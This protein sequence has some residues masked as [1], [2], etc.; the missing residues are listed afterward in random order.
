MSTENEDEV[1]DELST[2]SVLIGRLMDRT[3]VKPRD[4]A[5]VVGEALKVPY[6]TARRRLAGTTPWTIAELRKVAEHQNLSF[7]S[8]FT[9][10][11][12][13]P[14][15]AAMLQIDEQLLP[16][17]VWI[18]KA[19]RRSRSGPL[20]AYRDAQQA[21]IVGRPQDAPNGVTY[22]LTR[23]EIQFE[24]QPGRRVAVLDDEVDHADSI[25][26]YLKQQGLDATAF[27]SIKTLN[28]ARATE[29]FEG[30]VLD[31]LI[32]KE[33]VLGT[34]E[35][36]RAQSPDCPIIVL[37]GQV[38]VGKVKEAELANVAMNYR[39]QYLDKPARSSSVLS[40]LEAA[41]AAM[42]KP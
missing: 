23:L 35:S 24:A 15:E 8:L 18:G 3:N 26:K 41:F 5:K 27:F 31:W 2:E 1:V 32:R 21:L 4:R 22:A 17:H 34:I 9:D 25:T 42:D 40:M 38:E 16:C 11:P 30:Y 37:T 28:K 33:S 19:E 7:E 20:A 6:Q 13:T 12:S 14:G 29:E 10:A 36:I 39:V